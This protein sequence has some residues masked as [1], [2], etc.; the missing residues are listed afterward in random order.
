MCEIGFGT[1]LK[2]EQSLFHNCYYCQEDGSA[3]LGVVGAWWPLAT[4]REVSRGGKWGAWAGTVTV[5]GEPRVN[6]LGEL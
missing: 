1:T 3:L 6:S 4:Q 2:V 5:A